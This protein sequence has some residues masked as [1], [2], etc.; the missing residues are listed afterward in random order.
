MSARRFFVA[1]AR[2][3]GETVAIEGGDA[4]KIA[5]VLRLRDG[6]TIEI[7]DA[8]GNGFEARVRCDADGVRA[9]LIAARESLPAIALQVDVAQA[10]PKGS[11]MDFVIEKATELGAAAI[12]PVYS[13][14]SVVQDLGASKLER[15]RR[16]AQAAAAQCDRRDI[17]SVAGPVPLEHLLERC[18]AYDLVVMPWEAAAPVPLRESLPGW[19]A[20]VRRV[21]AIV[22]PEGGFSANEAALAAARGARLVSLGPRIL[23]SE[24][25]ALALLA[26]LTYAGE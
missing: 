10:I 9:E 11:K 7:V 1:G 22:G 16:L 18:G 19:L 24:T 12:L 5:N 4:H 6:D 23:R 26:I 14:R 20:G 8:A 2:G 13:E 25:A 17:P 21:L 15:W 3:A